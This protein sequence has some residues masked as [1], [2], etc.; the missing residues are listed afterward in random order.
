[1]SKARYTERVTIGFTPDQN[2][3]LEELVR[4]RSRKGEE[5]NKADLIRTALTFYFMHQDDLPGSRKAIARSVEGKIAEVDRK[6]DHLTETLEN[7][8]ERV[9]KRR[10]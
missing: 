9:T 8:I 5:V 4:V 7:F 1:M 10:S 3:R 6:V 2:R